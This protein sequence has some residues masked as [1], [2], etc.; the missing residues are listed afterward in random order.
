SASALD[1]HGVRTNFA[2]IDTREI[3]R[4]IRCQISSRGA[5]FVEELLGCRLTVHAAAG[6][7][8][9]GENEST[10]RLNFDDRIAYAA[11]VVHLHP[12]T[13]QA[14]GCLGTA[15]DEVAGYTAGGEAVPIVP[16]PVEFVC[17]G[18]ERQGGIRDPAG[19]DHGSGLAKRL[20][21]RRTPEVGVRAHDA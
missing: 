21:Q 10:G 7:W 16:G 9:L 2:E 17:G 6:P 5:D 4:D 14:A 1:S 19:D 20:H 3:S 18:C 12:V 13:P 15:F 11:I 8:R